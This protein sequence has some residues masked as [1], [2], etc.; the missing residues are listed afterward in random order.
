MAYIRY[1]SL[2]GFSRLSVR[3]S[4]SLPAGGVPVGTR[5]APIGDGR[6]APRG[7]HRHRPERPDGTTEATP[8][9]APHPPPSLAPPSSA[10]PPPAHALGPAPRRRL[11][12]LGPIEAAGRHSRLARLPRRGCA[13]GSQP[14]GRNKKADS[15]ARTPG[16]PATPRRPSPSPPCRET[17]ARGARSLAGA[18]LA[19]RPSSMLRARLGRLHDMGAHISRSARA[20]LPAWTLAPGSAGRVSGKRE[21]TRERPGGGLTSTPAGKLAWR[22]ERAPSRDACVPDPDRPDR[23]WLCSWSPGTP[24]PASPLPTATSPTGPTEDTSPH[25]VGARCRTRPRSG[26]R[27]GPE[28]TSPS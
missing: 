15:N 26:R 7:A 18:A 8:A 20:S 23:D 28:S 1:E 6:K 22:G 11:S 21:R 12:G 14:S 5:R 9:T 16:G 13:R 25:A 24:M 2:P 3:G 19:K 10:E 4:L 17:P 27:V